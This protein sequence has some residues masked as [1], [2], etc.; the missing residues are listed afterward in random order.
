M[1]FTLQMM[2]A[3]AK[4]RRFV[5]VYL[6]RSLVLL[7]IGVLHGILFWVGDILAIYAALGVLLLLFRHMR[8]R[9]LLIWAVVILLLPSLFMI[10]ANLLLEFARQDPAAAAQIDAMFADV[11]PRMRRWN[12]RRLSTRQAVLPRSPHNARQNSSRCGLR[13]IHP[14]KHLCHV[15]GRGLHR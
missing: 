12:E 9:N 3:E 7:V 4:G 2:R 11:S 10:G 1:G 5:P 6:R 13:P 8:P 14:A 15:S